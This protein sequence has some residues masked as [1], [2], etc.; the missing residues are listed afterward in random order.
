MPECIYC[1]RSVEP[2]DA[3]AG[4][5]DGLHAHEKCRKV[6]ATWRRRALE[7]GDQSGARA[8]SLAMPL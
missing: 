3:A 2:A 1:R 4:M 8:V 6:S 5:P 7:G